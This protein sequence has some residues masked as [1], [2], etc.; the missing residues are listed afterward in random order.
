[1]P[2]RPRFDAPDL[3]SHVFGRGI[4]RRPVFETRDDI[5]FF[6]SLLACQVRAGRIEI[7]SFSILTTH[8]HLVVRS[9]TG[10][11]SAVMMFVLNQYVRR[12]NRLRRR[13]G[14]LLRGRFG[15]RPVLSEVYFITLVRY[16]DQN[17]P[18]ARL[19]TTAPEYPY[20][21]AAHYVAARRPAWLSTEDIDAHM[22]HPP[23]RGRAEAYLRAFGAPLTEAERRLVALR[24]SRPPSAEE[25][26]DDLVGAAPEAVRDWM[27]RKA[28]MADH[29]RPGQ[30]CA[31]AAVIARALAS[32]GPWK[33]GLWLR[34][35]SGRRRDG[36]PILEAGLLWDLGGLVLAEIATLTARGASAVARRVTEHRRLLTMDPQYAA[37][38]AEAAHRALALQWGALQGEEDGGE[39]SAADPGS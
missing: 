21:S 14:S 27:E 3:V 38:A 4:A 22:G 30:P 33:G 29:T 26:L 36:Q 1:M 9:P 19:A 25:P 11:L 15:S 12:F 10:E 24:L 31:D 16:V 17:A 35:S 18:G 34:G 20:G 37:L 8:Y 32:P 28:R 7:L 39:S 6:L 23:P 2:R 5:R 13:D